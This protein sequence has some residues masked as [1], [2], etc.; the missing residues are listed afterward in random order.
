MH[1][2][3][4]LTLVR[5]GLLAVDH[6]RNPKL[7]DAHAETRRPECLL[8]RH[9]HVAVLSQR[10]EDALAI[11]LVFDMDRHIHARG[12]FIT[13]RRSI[14]A[15]QSFIADG[16]RR[17]HDQFMGFRRELIRARHFAPGHLEGYLAAE[18]LLVEFECG[19]ALAVEVYIWIQL[20]EYSPLFDV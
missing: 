7:I 16:E 17:T 10:V 4:A 18:N 9:R 3:G 14:S 12:L 5:G 15:H 6:P 20:H 8:K 1:F 13:I 2:S 19:L 11:S